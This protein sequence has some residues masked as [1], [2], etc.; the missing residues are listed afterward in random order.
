MLEFKMPQ[1]DQFAWINPDLVCAVATNEQMS[2]RSPKTG[3]LV[4][5]AG[6]HKLSLV[7]SAADVSARLRATREQAV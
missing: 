3:C 1:V 4:M 2:G 5:L 6:G 7:D